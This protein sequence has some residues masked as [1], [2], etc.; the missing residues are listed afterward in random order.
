VDVVFVSALE[1]RGDLNSMAINLAQ[2]VAGD[3]RY[4]LVLSRS[5]QPHIHL[6]GDGQ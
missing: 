5:Q 3:A 2:W 1:G 4:G 6:F